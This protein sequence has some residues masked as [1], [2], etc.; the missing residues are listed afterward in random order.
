MH[1]LHRMTSA[2]SAPPLVLGWVVVGLGL[3]SSPSTYAGQPH[4]SPG[5]VG[6]AGTQWPGEGASPEGG[7]REEMAPANPYGFTYNTSAQQCASC[8]HQNHLSEW[9]DAAGS[10]IPAQNIWDAGDATSVDLGQEPIPG[11]TTEKGSLHS[12]AWKD[13]YFQSIYQDQPD[14]GK[15]MCQRCH[16][17]TVAVSATRS[18]GVYAPRARGTMAANVDEGVTCVSCHLDTSGNILGPEAKDGAHDVVASVAFADGVTLCASCHDDPVFGAF[19]RTVTEH[20]EQ[21]ATATEDW[22]CVDCHMT[23]DDLGDDD[24]FHAMPGGTSPSQRGKALEVMVPSS[25]S[26]T[27]PVVVRVDNVGAGHNAPTGDRFRAYVLATRITNGAGVVLVD[28]KTFFTPI[29]NSPVFKEQV[30]YERQDPIAF[31]QS[32]QVSYGTLPAGSYKIH[33]EI[34]YYQIKPTTLQWYDGTVE[35]VDAYGFAVVETV[36]KS[37]TISG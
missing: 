33:V 26:S 7:E 27:S 12:L 18:L 23:R 8:H 21:M 25:T 6:M 28:K 3:L 15:G 11:D 31:E 36:D 37:L 9:A 29:T 19:S 24:F 13:W 16:L 22:T 10:D 35:T 14:A 20:Q 1:F 2:C 5:H 4:V 30:A 32:A 34:Q 17:P